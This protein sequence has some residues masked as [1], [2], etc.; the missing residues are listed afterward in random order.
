MPTRTIHRI[1]AHKAGDCRKALYFYAAGVAPSNPPD[2]P[3]INRMETGR[4]MKP[5]IAAALRREEW[6][7]RPAPPMPDIPVTD[8]LRIS[9]VG[10][11]VMS[12]AEIT[13]G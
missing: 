8:T 1:P 5:A 11:L 13:A 6:Q 7:I 10:D 3:A 2:G 4:A 12:H 9:V